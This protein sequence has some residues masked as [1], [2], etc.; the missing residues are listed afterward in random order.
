MEQRVITKQLAGSEDLIKGIGKVTQIRGTGEKEITKLNVSELQ[1]SLVVDSIKKLE[2][3]DIN[4][5]GDTKTVIISDGSGTYNYIDNTWIK[6][7]S[8]VFKVDSMSGFNNLKSRSYDLVYVTGYHTKGDG[9]FGSNIFEW[10]ST[11][12]EPHNGGTIID[13]NAK[14]PSDWN[15]SY[16]VNSWYNYNSSTSGRY[17]LRYNSATNVKWFGARGV[18][19]TSDGT[20]FDYNDA[21]AIQA[22]IN[23][24]DSKQSQT[25]GGTVFIPSGKYPIKE[26]IETRIGTK[27]IG[28]GSTGLVSIDPYPSSGTVLILAIHKSDNS[29]WTETTL[30]S[31]NVTIPYQVMF[32]HIQGVA[33]MEDIGAIV[34]NNDTSKSVFCLVGLDKNPYDQAGFSQGHFKRLRI[35]SFRK[36]FY[37]S[38][39]SDCTFDSCGFEYNIDVFSV[40]SGY[41]SSNNERQGSFGGIRFMGCIFFGNYRDFISSGG[42]NYSGTFS[43]LLFSSCEFNSPDS[44]G[45]M[46]FFVTSSDNSII[47]NLNFTG[48]SLVGTGNNVGKPIIYMDTVNSKVS[49]LNFSSCSF[50]DVKFK[51]AYTGSSRDFDNFSLIGSTLDNTPITINY[52]MDGFIISN[53]NFINSTYLMLKGCNRGTISGNNFQK[54]SHD[55]TYDLDFNDDGSHYFTVVGNTFTSKG[56]HYHSASDNFKIVGNLNV[57]DEVNP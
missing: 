36:V 44:P 21:P 4:L 27:L 49:G 17:K 41:D 37:G 9:V 42:T 15:N 10:D 57:D 3:L 12:Q 30:K 40:T 31:K 52:E 6:S 22:A 46:A 7:D 11:C 14:F 38:H 54:T 34:Q 35:F 23:A 19:D 47:E 1:G 51:T 18:D 24:S 56:L 43:N 50:K 25:I 28:D 39:I 45:H 53:N 29:E 33:Q 16:S 2:E 5:L 55:K 26:T 32:N 48:C 20:H 8:G 13:P